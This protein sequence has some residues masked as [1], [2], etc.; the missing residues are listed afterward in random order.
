MV[1]GASAAAAAGGILKTK[2]LLSAVNTSEQNIKQS[3]TRSRQTVRV[4]RK[5]TNTHLKKK[6]LIKEKKNKNILRIKEKNT[7]FDY[8][9]KDAKRNK[10]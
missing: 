7:L 3:A 9:N 10:Q 6:Y 4:N 8:L 5:K 2:K 1:P